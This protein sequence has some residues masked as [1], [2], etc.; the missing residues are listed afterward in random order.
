LIHLQAEPN[1]S[2]AIDFSA[3]LI[4]WT[5]LHN[6]TTDIEGQV[7]LVDRSKPAGRVNLLDPWCGSVDNKI[8]DSRQNQQAIYYRV[9]SSPQAGQMDE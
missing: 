4:G 8:Y 9:V 3:D 7:I 6:L 2:Y 5:F 1:H